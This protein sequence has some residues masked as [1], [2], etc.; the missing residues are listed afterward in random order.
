MAN[1]IIGA[2]DPVRAK[3]KPPVRD[4]II[5]WAQALGC[6]TTPATQTSLNGVHTETYCPT[7]HGAQIVYTAVDGLGHTWAGGKSL[8]PESMVGKTSNR[9]SATDLIWDFFKSHPRAGQ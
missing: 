9:I 3:P 1:E 8:L 6:A 5:K 4:S 2:S 7:N